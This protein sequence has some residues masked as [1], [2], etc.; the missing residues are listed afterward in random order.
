MPSHVRSI[1]AMN[2]YEPDDKSFGKYIIGDGE[3]DATPNDG[4]VCTVNVSLVGT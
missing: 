2:I 1:G 3:G 4:A